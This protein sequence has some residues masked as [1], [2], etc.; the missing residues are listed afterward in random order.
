MHEPNTDKRKKALQRALEAIGSGVAITAATLWGM[1]VFT[2]WHV[3]THWGIPFTVSY[4]TDYANLC[5][6]CLVGNI[7]FWTASSYVVIEKREGS[8]SWQRK[9]SMVLNITILAGLLGAVALW[10]AYVGLAPG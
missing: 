2:S 10:V 1:I 6:T 8:I 4:D 3:V 7:L 9:K 5:L